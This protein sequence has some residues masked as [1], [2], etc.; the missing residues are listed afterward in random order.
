V[1]ILTSLEAE[2]MRAA[3]CVLAVPHFAHGDLERFLFPGEQ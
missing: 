2:R 1:G 3:G